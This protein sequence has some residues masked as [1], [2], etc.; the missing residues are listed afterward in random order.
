MF[1]LFKRF[2]MSEPLFIPVEDAA[3][4]N[5]V[6][7]TSLKS[8]YS[9]NKKDERFKLIAGKLYV[10]ENYKYPYADQLDDL[11]QKALIIAH[12]ENNLSREI[13]KILK[14]KES[15]V[16]KYLYRFTFKQVKLA[17]QYI[18]ALEE[19]ISQ[20]SLLPMEELSYD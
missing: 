2:L 5:D 4:I 14:I 6:D 20:N 1:F 9:K 15:T 17:K 11:R 19:Y 18:K 13:A 7:L 10:I 12:N 16:S 3:T 8:L